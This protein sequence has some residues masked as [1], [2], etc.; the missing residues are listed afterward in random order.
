MAMTI[1]MKDRATLVEAITV[2]VDRQ[3]KEDARLLDAKG[4]DVPRLVRDFL[5]AEFPKIK[6]K[7]N[8]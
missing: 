1:P 2:K 5:K 7:L 8:A 3:L 4:V 6:A